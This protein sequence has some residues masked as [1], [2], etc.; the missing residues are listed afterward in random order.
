MRTDIKYESFTWHFGVVESRNDP[1]KLGRLKV[2]F[3]G[4]HSEDKAAIPTSALPWATVIDKDSQTSG[5]GG[6]N[7]GIVPGAWVIGFF[8][9]GARYQ[10]P[11]V[12]GAISGIP[13]NVADI[14]KG[15]SDP[16]GLFPR[17]DN[18]DLNKLQEPDT[19]R[20]ARNEKAESHL[21]IKKRRAAKIPNIPLAKAPTT[22]FEVIPEKPGIDYSNLTW[23]EPDARNNDG[24]ST[25]YANNKISAYP[26]NHVR[27]T[28]SGHIFEVDDTPN[29]ERINTQ[30]KSG[31]Y[32]EIIADGSRATKIKGS[33]YEI[34]VKDKNVYIDGKLNITVKGDTKLLVQGNMYTEVEKDY[35]LTVRGDK[36]EKI[37]GNHQTEIL[38]DRSTQING[39]NMITIGD[40]DNANSGHDITTILATETIKVGGTHSET[41]T[42]NVKIDYVSNEIKSTFGNVTEIVKGNKDTGIIGN[43]NLGVTLNY[44][45][46]TKAN[47]VIIV[48][49]E[50]AETIT[51]TIS[52]TYSNTLTETVTGAVSQ[53]YSNSHAITTTL[54]THTGTIDAA[55][56]VLAG[57]DDID[58]DGH[59]HTAQGA[60]ANTSGSKT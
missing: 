28:E 13:T 32:Q 17:N 11:M 9:N 36:I 46:K 33:D 22:D 20:L 21:S 49:G 56:N 58:L 42:G 54:T 41:V 40:K 27:E 19:S 55:V 2:R 43:Y 53:T 5:V 44:N 57:E 10:K 29:Y 59:F 35:F 50:R 45:E 38:S 47:S 18:D 37:G 4:V 3:Y 25:N 15:F 31:T 6:P 24:Q 23:N 1:L 26:F 16:S 14:E 52:H 30:H 34:V 51:G 39:N 60:T 7:T 8:I 12:L 48:E